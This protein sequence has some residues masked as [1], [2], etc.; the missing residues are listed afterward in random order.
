MVNANGR[1]G[2][3]RAEW[4]SAQ[5]ATVWPGQCVPVP[6]VGN[7][8]GVSR[9]S[10]SDST[11]PAGIWLLA[12]LPRVGRAPI[13]RI[14]GAGDPWS[15]RSS[16]GDGGRSRRGVHSLLPANACVSGARDPVH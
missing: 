14:V 1:P 13:G 11:V 16:G 12:T 4:L 7:G 5:P 8:T 6:Q 15:R 2:N 3:G 10:F 9:S